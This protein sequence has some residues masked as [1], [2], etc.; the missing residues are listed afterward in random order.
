ML[1][2]STKIATKIDMF[3]V[4]KLVL[5]GL[6]SL[7]SLLGL[8]GA[9]FAQAENITT[10]PTCEP[11]RISYGDWQT[12]GAGSLMTDAPEYSGKC[13][14]NMTMSSGAFDIDCSPPP[15][16]RFFN[17]ATSEWT[18]VP[19]FNVKRINA[20]LCTADYIT[21]AIC[22]AGGVLTKGSNG[23]FVCAYNVAPVSCPTGKTL[24]MVNNQA[25]CQQALTCPTGQTLSIA[26]NQ[27]FCQQAA[28]CS[29]G[30]T[31]S[32]INNQAWCSSK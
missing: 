2:K 21:T 16:A 23:V 22:S 11:S 28:T 24:L 1:S 27:A 19:L 25:V 12:K 5:L 30:Q 15:F 17:S 29:N 7:F 31:M 26:N 4:Q 18:K 14:T 6:F 32:V 13:K 20:R 3:F 9:S 8:F 10:T